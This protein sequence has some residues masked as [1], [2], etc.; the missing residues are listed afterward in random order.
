[1]S[2][3]IGAARELAW[4]FE[5]LLKTVLDRYEHLDGPLRHDHGNNAELTVDLVRLRLAEV[6]RRFGDIDIAFDEAHSQ[7][8]HIS[9][10]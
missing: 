8:A 5:S 7:A 6:I 2:G 1:M 3:T 4:A 9:P 10:A